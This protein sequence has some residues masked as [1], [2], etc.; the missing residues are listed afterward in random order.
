MTTDSPAPSPH[1][2]HIGSYRIL[3]VLGEGAYGV[4]YRAHCPNR[5]QDVAIKV[6]L[7]ESP[8]R[9]V[10]SRFK[11]ERRALAMMSHDSIAKLLDV[12]ETED[13]R[14]FVAMELVEGL[15]LT[16]H[17]DRYRLS[18]EERLRLFQQVCDG[19]QHAHSK[20]VFHRDLKPG[21]VLCVRDGNSSSAKIVDFGLAKARHREALGGS[22]VSAGDAVGTPEYMPPEQARG[23]DV[24]ATSDVYSLGVVLYELLVGDLPFP[25]AEL[26]R[27]GTMEMG[28]IITEEEPP[29]PS[30]RLLRREDRAEVA[31]SRRVSV[32]FLTSA[33]R[34]DLDWLVMRAIE[35]QQSDR[36]DS[37]SA[38]SADVER[39]LSTEPL[40]ARPP[41]TTYYVRKFT[42]RYRLQLSAA[43]LTIAASIAFGGWALLERAEAKHQETL[44]QEQRSE[45]ERQTGIAQANERKFESKVSEFNQLA[46]VVRYDETVAGAKELLGQAAW[47]AA[48]PGMESWLRD[49]DELL[50]MRDDIELTIDSLRKDALPWT[51][52][53]R[54]ADRRV[55]TERFAQ[56]ELL[57]RQLASLR[58]AQAVRDGAPIPAVAL[59]AEQQAMDADALNSLA[60][61]RVAPQPSDRRVWGEEPLGLAAARLCVDKATDDPARS[62]YLDTL[63]WA[64]LA[65]GQDAEARQ[66]AAAALDAAQDDAKGKYESRQRNIESAI[67]R[68]AEILTAAEQD[69]ETMTAAV[70]VRQTYAFAPENEAQSFLHDT[71]VDLLAK[72]DR[73][74]ASERAVIAQRLEWARQIDALSQSHPNAAVTWGAARNGISASNKYA[75]QLIELR[76]EDVLGLV[77]LGPNPKTGYFEFYHLRSAWDG[78]SDPRE[79][80]IPTHGEDGSIE[81]TDDTGIV[82]VLLPAGAVMLGS[83]DDDETAPYYDAQRN[84]DEDIHPVTLSP[85]FLARHELTQGQWS[86]LWSGADGLR[87]PSYYSAGGTVAG[88]QTTLAHPVEQVDWSM[89]RDLLASHGLDLPTE[90]QWEH[91]CRGSTTTPWNQPLAE[92]KT[93]ANLASQDAKP[94]GVAW[95]LE[96]WRDGHV[97]HAPVGSFLANVFGLYDVHGNVA[98][99]CLDAKSPYGSERTGDGLRPGGDDFSVRVLRGGSFSGTTAL[100]RSANRY[101][102]APSLRGHDLGLRPA[103]TSRLRD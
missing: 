91:G 59:S 25:S 77:P 101:D 4:V 39:Y 10:L 11:Q 19:V 70:T 79:I 81:V 13:G 49:C 7:S 20:G 57:G 100:A 55:D 40:E 30:Q 3:R 29:R 15:P 38:L 103:R 33:L 88:T 31:S 102:N 21:N 5:R 73:L 34:R 68:A 75:G 37:A 28:R 95:Q 64:L 67:E 93:V 85:F 6:L 62:D 97:V 84:P 24:D 1:P 51:E 86:R 61:A 92:L 56:W 63:A 23:D 52:E 44:A 43:M 27:H 96:S 71:L 26:R 45:A 36:Y 50:G 16:A 42:R 76:P 80:A 89:S 58:H 12:G 72:F 78:K 90:A 66:T 98:E 47:P 9:D 60:W 83:Q 65:N 53:Q 18:L 87:R 22:M 48:I 54:E 35:K 69:Y 94:F 74:E 82:F 17:C 14:P 2:D 41:S 32:G 99:W 8:T 46:G